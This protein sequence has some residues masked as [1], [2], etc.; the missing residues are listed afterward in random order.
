MS[1]E[2]AASRGSILAKKL[3]YNV[4][5]GKLARVHFISRV[6]ILLESVYTR[7]QQ[8]VSILCLST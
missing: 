5:R 6:H 8:A 1:M 4:E 2:K 7:T 3:T